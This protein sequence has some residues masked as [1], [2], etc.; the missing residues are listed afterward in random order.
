MKKVLNITLC[1]ILFALVFTSCSTV[2]GG[3]S[4][5]NDEELYAAAIERY[6][7][8]VLQADLDTFLDSLDPLGRL[9]P[10]PEAIEQLRESASESA[11]PGEAYV[12]EITTVEESTSR[13][14]VDVAL[15]MRIDFDKNGE[16]YEETA[17]LTF[18]LTFKDGVW[19]IFDFRK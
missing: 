19:R 9:Y 8:S 4:E 10:A 7:N 15:F 16:F 1:F 12:E 17:N 11:L 13:A 3:S 5:N 18:E 2:T 14:I 6:F